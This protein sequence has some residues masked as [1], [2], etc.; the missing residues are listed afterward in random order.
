MMDL[1]K[2]SFSKDIPFVM[3]NDTILENV[4]RIVMS[5]DPVQ[6]EIPLF[7]IWDRKVLSD[8]EVVIK[9]RI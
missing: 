1:G 2:F 9:R 7:I 3:V 8:N 4:D 6:R 5:S